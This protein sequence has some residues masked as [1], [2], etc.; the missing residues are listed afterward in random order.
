MSAL[1]GLPQA[2]HTPPRTEDE[3][4][5]QHRALC[6]EVSPELF[7]PNYGERVSDA[8]QICVR[9]EVRADC[10]DYAMTHNESHGIWG[11]KTEEERRQMRRTRKVGE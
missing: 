2:S 5:W 10:L 9:C 7:F 8:K 11:G 6:L 1:P 3:T 4:R